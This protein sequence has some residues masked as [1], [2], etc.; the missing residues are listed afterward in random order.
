MFHTTLSNAGYGI[1]C[2]LKDY[3][4]TSNNLE[5][6]SNETEKRGFRCVTKY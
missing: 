2:R 1:V 6:F 3:L 5:A 4:K